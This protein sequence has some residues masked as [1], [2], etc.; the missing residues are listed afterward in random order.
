MKAAVIGASIT[1]CLVVAVLGGFANSR[2]AWAQRA[3]PRDMVANE[4][5]IVL[6][7]TAGD[8]GQQITV[9]DPHQ[10]VMSVYWVDNEGKLALKSVRK[11]LW[12]L[13]MVDFNGVSPQSREVRSLVEPR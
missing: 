7:A 10:R 11:I 1:A 6:T 13:Q 9:I 2:E 5:L 12:D 8:N 3:L 4:G